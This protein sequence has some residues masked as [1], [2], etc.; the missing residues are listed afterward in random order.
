MQVVGASV[1]V[2]VSTADLNDELLAMMGPMPWTVNTPQEAIM[3]VWRNDLREKLEAT[4]LTMTIFCSRGLTHA[5]WQSSNHTTLSPYWRYHEAI[6]AG[7]ELWI[8]EP[9]GLQPYCRHQWIVTCLT[10]ES[11]FLKMRQRSVELEFAADMLPDC[12]CVVLSMGGSIMD[13][14]RFM[15]IEPAYHA[16][17]H[18]QLKGLVVSGLLDVCPCLFPS[19]P[20]ATGD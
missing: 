19:D 15:N 10:A 8:I 14:V 2:N 13:W 1:K 3:R 7:R 4:A 5:A 9:L 17:S 11:S 12:T 16:R 20:I 6:Q 18:K